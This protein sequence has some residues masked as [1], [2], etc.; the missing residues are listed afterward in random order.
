MFIFFLFFS[1]FLSLFQSLSLA[2]IEWNKID[3]RNYT[4]DKKDKRPLLVIPALIISKKYLDKVI[5]Y[6][7]SKECKFCEKIRRN[8]RVS[9]KFI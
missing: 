5:C 1:L 4:L 8:V 7:K 9:E 2:V 3:S 6:R